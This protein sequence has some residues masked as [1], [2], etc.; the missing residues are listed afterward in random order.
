M[1]LPTT[2]AARRSL[3]LPGDEREPKRSRHE[4]RAGTCVLWQYR[5]MPGQLP[6]TAGRLTGNAAVADGE[7]FLAQCFLLVAVQ[8]G[9]AK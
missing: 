9:G 1:K 6:R 3:A 7:V 8:D 4:V 5:R 2:G